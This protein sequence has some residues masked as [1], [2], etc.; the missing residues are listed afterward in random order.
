V[1]EATWAKKD[2]DDS[3]KFTAKGKDVELAPGLVWVSMVSDTTDV[4]Y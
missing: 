3:L 2:L 4:T 1:V